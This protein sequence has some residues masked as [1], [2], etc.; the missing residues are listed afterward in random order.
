MVVHRFYLWLNSLDNKAFFSSLSAHFS[1]AFVCTKP[2]CS[3]S[4]PL[5]LIYRHFWIKCCHV[6][7]PSVQKHVQ[8]QCGRQKRKA[9]MIMT[10]LVNFNWP[11]YWFIIPALSP[12]TWASADCNQFPHWMLIPSDVQGFQLFIIVDHHICTLEE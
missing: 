3:G 11:L 2:D 9:K 4:S 7:C 12:Q 6:L 10:F 1:L 8:E 5:T